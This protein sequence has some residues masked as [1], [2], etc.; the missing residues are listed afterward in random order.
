MPGPDFGGEGFNA[1]RDDIIDRVRF[2]QS[3]VTSVSTESGLA[4]SDLLERHRFLNPSS[5]IVV[6]RTQ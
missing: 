4:T 3:V 6:T 2:H 5:R 1:A